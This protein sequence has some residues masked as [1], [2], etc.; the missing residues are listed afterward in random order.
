MYKEIIVIP[1]SEA[2]KMR[3]RETELL[4]LS[5][6]TCLH[7]IVGSGTRLNNFTFNVLLSTANL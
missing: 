3:R 1:I 6:Y 7:G 5:S 2:G 4:C